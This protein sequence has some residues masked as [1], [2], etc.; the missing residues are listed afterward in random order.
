MV[1]IVT[2]PYTIRC[3]DCGYETENFHGWSFAKFDCLTPN[4]P[5]M[6]HNWEPTKDK[7]EEN[8]E[9]QEG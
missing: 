5:N 3:K 1:K 6:L 4:Q 8:A 9:A 2:K 7:E